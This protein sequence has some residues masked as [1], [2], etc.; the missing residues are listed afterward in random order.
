[1]CHTLYVPMTAN[2]SSYGLY[3]FLHA[4]ITFY[5]ISSG[6]LWL[7]V[8]L[9]HNTLWFVILWIFAYYSTHALAGLLCD[10][11][12]SDCGICHLGLLSRLLVYMISHSLFNEFM[13][14]S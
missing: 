13:E 5:V 10:F 2:H 4:T 1:M 9:C 3:I 14:Y 7:V 12:S 8:W 6:T 11:Q